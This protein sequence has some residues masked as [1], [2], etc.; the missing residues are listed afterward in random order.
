MI[1]GLRSL[2]GVVCHVDTG[3]MNAVLLRENELTTAEPLETEAPTEVVTP[4]IPA[5]VDQPKP[6]P[7]GFGAAQLRVLPLAI[8]TVFTLVAVGLYAYRGD[9]VGS[10]GIALF[11]S[12]W[13]GGGF[14]FLGGGILWSIGEM[15]KD[16]IH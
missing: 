10:M 9:L 14:G 1:Q 13:L 15:E 11:L 5:V 8:L 2:P 6:E 7:I 3:E 4:E 16:G 12:M